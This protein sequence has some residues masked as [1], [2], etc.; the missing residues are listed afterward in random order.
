MYG[1]IGID[2]DSQLSE[3]KAKASVIERKLGFL[4]SNFTLPFHISL[5]M[6]FDIEDELWGKIVEDVLGIFQ[7]LQPFEVEVS[8]IEY[9]ETICWIKMKDNQKLSEA[10]KLLYDFLLRKYDV[11]LHEY[12][13]D[14]QFHTTLFMDDDKS[15]VL[16]AYNS[17]KNEPLPKV[18]KINKLI[19]GS[20]P[21]GALGTY[22]VNKEFLLKKS[23]ASVE[24]NDADM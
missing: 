16:E 15:K 21:N 6:P 8:G 4:H 10:H 5:K 17:I 18:L 1:W 9:L 23:A 22:Q 13:L 3:I 20:S 12:D 11:P 7:T 2:V 24:K 14:Y 19:I